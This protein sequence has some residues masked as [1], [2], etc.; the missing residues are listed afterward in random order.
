MLPCQGCRPRRAGRVH[1]VRR[2][3]L[4]AHT[5]C[6]DPGG[7]KPSIYRYFSDSINH[8]GLE[9]ALLDLHTSG[10]RTVHLATRTSC[11]RDGSALTHFSVK[12]EVQSEVSLCTHV[13]IVSTLEGICCSTEQLPLQSFEHPDVAQQGWRSRVLQDTFGVSYGPHS[14]PVSSTRPNGEEHYSPWS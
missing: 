4:R 10:A 14:R 11:K 3:P 9:R 13:E 2:L 5:K 1:F 6:S 12:W 7:D 8:T